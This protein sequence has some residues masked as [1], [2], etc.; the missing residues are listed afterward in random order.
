MKQYIHCK[1]WGKR[2]LLS[3]PGC[4]L[5]VHGI[6]CKIGGYLNKGMH[7]SCM[8]WLLSLVQNPLTGKFFFWVEKFHKSH[9]I[10]TTKHIFST[11]YYKITENSKETYRKIL[12]HFQKSL[13]RAKD[14]VHVLLVALASPLLHHHLHCLLQHMHQ[15]LSNITAVILQI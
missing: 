3:S 11:I 6:K 4:R 10:R 8:N 5:Q 13:G 15:T 2:C 7:M 1:L 9:D 14:Q 12:T